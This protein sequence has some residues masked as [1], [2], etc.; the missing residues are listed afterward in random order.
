[1]IAASAIA[2]N[3]AGT[4]SKTTTKDSTAPVTYAYTI[5]HPDNW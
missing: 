5:D 4:D 2:C 3:N 1:M